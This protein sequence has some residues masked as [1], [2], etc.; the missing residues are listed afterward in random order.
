MV[1]PL[2]TIAQEIEFQHEYWKG[3]SFQIIAGI[4]WI[5]AE[6]MNWL[7]APPG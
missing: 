3:H 1:S 7:L 4:A 6:C 2:N 5:K